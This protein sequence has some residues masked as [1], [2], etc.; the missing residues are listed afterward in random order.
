MTQDAPHRAETADVTPTGAGDLGPFLAGRWRVE[1]SLR[2]GDEEGTFIGTAE[3]V[4]RAPTTQDGRVVER[5]DWTEHGRLRLGRY[6]G[7]AQRRLELVRGEG[8]AG[9]ASG[10]TR[11]DGWEVRFDDG[12]PFHALDLSG[13]VCA[14][15]HPCGED[16]YEGDYRVLGEDAFDVRW[17]VRGPHKDQWIVSRYRRM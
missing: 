6:D 17:R 13:G 7:V 5:M 15:V 1:R 14:A 2:E 9:L 11:W 12:R 3:F 10:A 4:V 16:V 8:S